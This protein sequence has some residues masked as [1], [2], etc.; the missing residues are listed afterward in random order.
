MIQWHTQAG[1]I[2][3][4]IKVKIYFTLPEISA[5][6]IATW[7]FHVDDSD[8]SR[9]DTIVG[10]YQLIAL[11]LNLKFSEHVIE[12]NDGFFKGLTVA[13]IDPRTCEFKILNTGNITP[14][15]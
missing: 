11:V 13:L 14:E 2:T 9:Y 10:R 6:K 8:K 5:T 15:E 3:T 12:E 1:S 4:N 7:Y